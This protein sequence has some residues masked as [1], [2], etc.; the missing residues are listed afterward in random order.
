MMCAATSSS[1]SA[2]PTGLTWTSP[3]GSAL[4]RAEGCVEIRF[5]RRGG[6]TV[7]LDLYQ[8]G[9]A[10]ARFPK[11]FG[12]G[13]LEA[14]LINLAGGVTGADCFRQRV[15]FA[16]GAKAVVTTQA[17]EKIY[18]ASRNDP[19][20]RIEN[21]LTVEA[22]VFAEWLP[23]ETIFFDGGRLERSLHVQL[24]QGAKFLASEA[25]V[26]GRTA[27]GEAVRSG[28]LRDN[29]RVHIG[30]HIAFADGFCLDG[31]IQD[32]LD[33][34]AIADGGRAV[35]TVLYA[36]DDAAAYLEPARAAL[37]DCREKGGRAA[38]SCLGSVLHARFIAADGAL[39]RATLIPYIETIRAAAGSI[40]VLPK[41]W[42]C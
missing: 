6:K 33:R 12:G 2:A 42:R 1:K 32:R 21:R 25:L 40:G 34:K 30:G 41:L 15:H 8:A 35:A 11:V 22:G 16:E 3:P 19:P 4:P 37:A 29:W 9:S 7:L 23:Q 20:A 38:V 13:A 18:K 36:G 14:V 10:K 24:D 26:F 27:M 5:G 28:F 39:L 31:A 17:A